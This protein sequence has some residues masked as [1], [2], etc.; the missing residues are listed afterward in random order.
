MVLNADNRT[1]THTYMSAH[2]FTHMRRWLL[3]FIH[4]NVGLA[5]SQIQSR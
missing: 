1:D 5:D 2:T 4:N 3:S